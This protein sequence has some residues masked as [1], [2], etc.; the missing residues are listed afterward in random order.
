VSR[1]AAVAALVALSGLAFA[2][3]TPPAPKPAC[4]STGPA[5]EP[6]PPDVM[7]QALAD[8]GLTVDDLGF[9]PKGTWARYPN[10]IPFKMPFF[11]DLLAHPLDT[12]EFTRTLGNAV[13]DL[14]TTTSLQTPPKEGPGSLFR[15]AIALGTDRLVGGFRGFGFA[16][17]DPKPAA[18]EPLADAL[19]RLYTAAGDL[20]SADPM[21]LAEKAKVVPAPLHLP[22]ARLVLALI[23]ARSWIDR[24]LRD[25]PR[26]VQDAVW[27]ELPG[28]LEATPDANRY[29]PELEDAARRVDSYSLYYGC[30]KALE[31][32]QR[33]R[34]EIQAVPR[35]TREEPAEEE[36]KPPRVESIDWPDFELRLK[37]PWG[38]VLFDNSGLN[39]QSADSPFLV[40]RPWPRNNWSGTLGA[41]GP[42]R[43]L[44]VA[45]L[46]DADDR[47]GEDYGVNL[48]EGEPH[49]GEVA[50]GI[51]GC[52]IVYAAGTKRTYWK[53]SRLGLGAGV[54]G[55]GVLVD[56]GGDDEYRSLTGQG[57]GF[58]GIGLLL[59]AGGDDSYALEEGDGQGYGGPGGIG[60]LAD[61]SGNDHY[62]AEPLPS[63]AGKDRADDHSI[64]KIV[65][66]NAQ[67]AGM[68]R[69]GDVSDGHA[70][71]GG[72]GALLDIDGDDVYEAGNFSQGLGY[73]FGTGLLYDGG[74]NDIY[75]SVYFSH[76]SGA[77]FAVG[78]VI[79]EGGDDQHL[80]Y[81][82]PKVD[83]SQ[84]PPG[85]G[86][87]FGWDVVNAMVI[88]RA[89][90]DRYESS[91]ISEGV[92]NIR[93]MSF[94]LDEGGDDVYVMDEGAQAFGAVDELP[95][96]VTPHRMSPF[97]FHLPQVAM[98]LDLGGTDRYLRRPAK[99]GDPVPDA[100]AG[101]DKTW[102][103]I[104]PHGPGAGPN[105]A[106]GRDVSRGRF[107]FLDAWPRRV[108]GP[109]TTPAA[110]LP[111]GTTSPSAPVN[112]KP[113]EPAMK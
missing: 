109:T 105:V 92:S 82:W 44:S 98:L 33:A 79:D 21:S 31:A 14:L 23:D 16:L 6:P 45:L 35:P 17:F 85:A 29:V 48:R 74:G 51:F 69:R 25:V 68:G 61:R 40:V 73:W 13:E 1:I 77:H 111:T 108:S 71:A 88:D 2:E 100:L 102:G 15:L 80:L 110:Q 26:A 87:G 19:A 91:I 7:A 8:A 49:V 72:L 97:A 53:T 59:D 34:W 96:Y 42:G 64:G 5:A 41:T 9:R 50:S 104:A 24:G 107:G 37:T 86:I 81:D 62:Y 4:P 10:V 18:Q 47:L 60:I 99:G 58:F 54:V 94:L 20:G 70:W 112:P 66:S 52:G 36:G 39:T 46:I 43:P 75:R 28:L 76:G 106:I 89:G 55:M 78:A 63:K 84:K 27:R 22:L 113:E 65:G 90:N 101:D 103:R 12:Y 38:T 93:S 32:V 11:D 67:G 3:D 56:E 57:A 30:L 95:T 83:L